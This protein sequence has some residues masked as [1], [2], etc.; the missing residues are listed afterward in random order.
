[1]GIH[2]RSAVG[3][4]AV[5]LT[6]Q[7]PEPLEIGRATTAPDPS[8]QT[9]LHPLHRSLS[10]T[11]LTPDSFLL[12]TII[13]DHRNMNASQ[14][15]TVDRRQWTLWTGWIPLVALFPMLYYRVAELWT[16]AEMRI[17]LLVLLLLPWL[18]VIRSRSALADNRPSLLS[19]QR[20]VPAILMFLA[21]CVLYGLAA[22][23]FSPWLANLAAVLIFTGW[24]LGHFVRN[25]WTTIAAWSALLA[26]TVGFP[27]AIFG[28]VESFLQ[29]TAA[30]ATSNT[31]D[32]LHV[33]HLWNGNSFELP[34]LRILVD[35]VC[36]GWT[37]VYGLVA[38]TLVLLIVGRHGLLTSVISL[39]LTLLWTATSYYLRLIAISFIHLQSGRDLSTGNDFVL[40][41]LGTFLLSVLFV[42]LTTRTCMILTRPI[43]LKDSSPGPTFDLLNRALRWP[44]H[45][46]TKKVIR[47][48]DVVDGTQESET[49][50][51]DK[52][53]SGHSA[54]TV[55]TETLSWQATPYAK[56]PVISASV[57]LIV[58]G[59]LPAYLLATGVVKSKFHVAA[60][61]ES[62]MQQIASAD[63]PESVGKWQR[64]ASDD[65]DTERSE[66]NGTANQWLYGKGTE[67]FS[68]SV[69]TPDVGW[70]DPGEE[71]TRVGWK[72]SVRAKEIPDYTTS[73]KQ[74]GIANWPIYIAELETDLGAAAYLFAST[75]TTDLEP[76]DLIPQYIEN[77]VPVQTNAQKINASDLLA[78]QTRT[79]DQSNLQFRLFIEPG[80]RLPRMELYELIEH[81][82]ILRHNAIGQNMSDSSTASLQTDGVGTNN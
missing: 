54:S 75:V 69:G 10:V 13:T 65:E 24:A 71:W 67:R 68:F 15:P 14:S 19:R 44:Q 56:W 59:L 47:E 39:V 34:D 12:I 23:N 53:L 36:G 28:D 29:L 58:V 26:T 20:S 7:C 64:I 40:L 42:W 16:N 3:L 77:N 11:S 81:F 50:E 82:D 6:F 72:I 73:T 80:A 35:Q 70:Q 57:F 62:T 38:I 66:V 48:D 32:A 52:Q 63:M 46:E 33:T 25:H 49:D 60:I 21:G 45:V 4:G 17:L 30:W 22:Y 43:S 27:F 55:A 61:P 5:Q 79:Q 31:L 76:C 8:S 2:E 74:A 51:L 41:Q 18:I 78:G 37:S 1:M 9:P